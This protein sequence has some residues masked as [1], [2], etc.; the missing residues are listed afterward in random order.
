ML[1]RYC[2]IARK[3][4]QTVRVS[5]IRFNNTVIILNRALL[6]EIYPG[7]KIIPYGQILRSS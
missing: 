3:S 4:G 5:G 6:P 2:L 7:Q 1:N